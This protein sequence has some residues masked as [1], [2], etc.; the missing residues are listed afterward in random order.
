MVAAGSATRFYSLVRDRARRTPHKPA[1][2][3]C[4]P[5]DAALI[6]ETCG[7]ACPGYEL[8]IWRSDNPDVEAA[9]GEIGQIGGRGASLML[10]YFDDQA[11]T[12][13]SSDAHGWFMTGDLG[14]MDERGYLRIAGA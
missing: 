2:P 4:F 5:D 10:G 1:L 11:A 12:E 8:K 7:R 3:D 9:T 6:I 13:A 14:W